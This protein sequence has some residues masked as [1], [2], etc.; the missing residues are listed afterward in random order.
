MSSTQNEDYIYFKD[1][2]VQLIEYIIK[3]KTQQISLSRIELSIDELLDV[4]QIKKLYISSIM[5]IFSIYHSFYRIFFNVSKK[6]QDI[7]NLLKQIRRLKDKI[8]FSRTHSMRDLA[9]SAK[10]EVY[11]PT[12]IHAVF[13]IDMIVFLEYVMLQFLNSGLELNFIEIDTGELIQHT[14][15]TEGR[16]NAQFEVLATF[17]VLFKYFF[18]FYQEK[19]SNDHVDNVSMSKY[20]DVE[21]EVF[22][23]KDTPPNNPI[24]SAEQTPQIHE[25][26]LDNSELIDNNISMY[27][28]L[29]KGND[30]GMGSHP[31]DN[32]VHYTYINGLDTDH[33]Q[34][35]RE[36]IVDLK[37]IVDSIYRNGDNTDLSLF[38]K[39]PFHAS[40]DYEN[41]AL[42]ETYIK[43]NLLK[44][45]ADFSYFY[46]ND[47][48]PISKLMR[49]YPRVYNIYL[50]QPH[51]FDKVDD[52]IK[53]SDET[54]VICK[55]LRRY[56]RLGKKVRSL[57]FDDKILILV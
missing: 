37:E 36:R 56:K 55:K 14:N 16:I 32:N 18:K 44:T 21:Q 51:L 9:K 1:K 54:Y 35:E 10:D 17:Y 28:N 42:N 45:L 29:P 24:R 23:P 39:A 48:I 15:L 38:K 3:E 13:T 27:N 43:K 19:I 34:G 41:S 25:Y 6:Q 40:R 7:L 52:S 49:D 53:I 8:V 47:P 2:I 57:K 20:A 4:L 5:K 46:K 30:N 26:E 22:G 11:Y 50:E 12:Q 31:Y 33:T